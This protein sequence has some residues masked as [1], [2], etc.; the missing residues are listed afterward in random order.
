MET[1]T[2]LNPANIIVTDIE[3]DTENETIDV[4]LKDPIFQVRDVVCLPLEGILPFLPIEEKE[5]L[6][7]ENSYEDIILIPLTDLV[8]C[9]RIDAAMLQVYCRDHLKAKALSMATFFNMEEKERQAYIN[10]MVNT[11]HYM[12]LGWINDLLNDIHEIKYCD[13]NYSNELR[14]YAIN[15]KKDY[16]GSGL[17]FDY[18]KTLLSSS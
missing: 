9:G 8:E 4:F 18:R 5:L 13:F 2:F 17:F 6:M 15:L 3:P 7:L 12:R 10:C 14:D 11:K 1:T 16:L